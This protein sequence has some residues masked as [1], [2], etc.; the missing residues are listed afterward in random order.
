[1]F[2]LAALALVAASTNS[3]PALLSNASWW[4]RI[5]MTMSGEGEPQACKFESSLDAAAKPCEVESDDIT[6]KAEASGSDGVLTKITFERRFSPDRP[7][8]PDLKAGDTLLGG[9][10]MSLAFDASGA[11]RA[12]KVV[13]VSGEK[14][15]YGCTEA[16]A[17][18]FEAKAGSREPNARAGYMTVLVY[19][20][21]EEL[22]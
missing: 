1:M 4:E 18:R 5:T 14:P 17:E 2:Q 10:V 7:E 13:A 21:S 16:Q 9:Q 12:C 6:A 8:L 11:V 22:V 19:G 3:S 15:S 20:H